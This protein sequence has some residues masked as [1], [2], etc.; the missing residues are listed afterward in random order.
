MTCQ[1]LRL[2][3][4]RNSLGNSLVGDNVVAIRARTMKQFSSSEIGIIPPLYLIGDVTRLW[5]RLSCTRCI[6][7]IRRDNERVS[8]IR[9]VGKLWI[10]NEIPL[11]RWKTIR[12][13]WQ[14]C[15][16]PRLSPR[17]DYGLLCNRVLIINRELQT[18]LD[19]SCTKLKSWFI[20]KLF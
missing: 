2:N 16:I 9:F 15:I 6:P 14:R 7:F 11:D 12:S 20:H 5:G 3:D 13:K 10:L 18:F 19:E 17:R 8:A 4:A 1:Y